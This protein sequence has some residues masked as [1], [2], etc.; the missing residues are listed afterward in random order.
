MSGET[1]KCDRTGKLV[2]PDGYAVLDLP[3]RGNVARF[4]TYTARFIGAD[5]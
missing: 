4:G 5:G 3:A 1:V 2:S